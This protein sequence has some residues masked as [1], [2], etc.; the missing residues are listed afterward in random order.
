MILT[1][2]TAYLLAQYADKTESKQGSLNIRASAAAML[3]MLLAI[4][5][6]VQGVVFVWQVLA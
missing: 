2:L 5:A 4:V 3:S 1:S 6:G